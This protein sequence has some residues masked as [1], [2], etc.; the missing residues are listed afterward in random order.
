MRHERQREKFETD[1]EIKQ[2]QQMLQIRKNKKQDL[3]VT[4]GT[5]NTNKRATQNNET[6]LKVTKTAKTHENEC[7]NFQKSGTK[8]TM[9]IK[10]VVGS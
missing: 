4:I 3:T 1:L 9:G 5:K 8:L 6:I 2:S 7:R 10:S